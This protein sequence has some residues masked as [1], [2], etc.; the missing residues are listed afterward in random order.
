MGPTNKDCRSS[1]WQILYPNNICLLEDKIQN[2]GMY[3]FLISYGSYAMDQRSGDGWISG[4]SQI[5]ALYERNSWTRFWGTPRE[6]RFSTEPNHPEYP[7]QEKG[8]SGGTKSSKRGSLSPRKTDRLP[9]LRILPGHWRQW[10]CRE[11][12]RPIYSCSSK[13]WYSG[14]RFKVGRNS[15]VNDEIPPDDILEGLYKLRIQPSGKL[16]TVLE[17]YNLETHQKKLGPDYHRLKAMVKRSIEQN[18][19]MKNFE[20][21]NGNFETSAVVKNQ[22]VKQ[23]EQGSLGDCWQW[24]A[25][26]QCSKG[27]N[28]SFRHDIS[29]RAKTT[30]P[31]SSPR[32]FM[33]QNERKAS[34]NASRTRSLRGRSPSGNMARLPC[35]DCLKG[36]CTTPFCEKWH[37]PECL[38]YKSENGCKFGDKCSHA[39]RQVDEQPRKKAKKNS[40][41][42]V[43]VMLKVTRQLA[44]VLHD[45]EPP[46]SSSILRKSSNILKPT[47]CVRFTEAVLRHADIRDQNPSLGMICPGDPHQR[48]PNAPKFED[49]SQEETELQERCAREA[50]WRLAKNIPNFK[51]KH[52]TAFFSPSENWCLPAPSTLEP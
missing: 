33:Q 42:S 52:K 31:N 6:D 11:L 28:C 25:N 22:R 48:N 9:D 10:F 40:D 38:C 43:V 36:T 34:K 27:D 14:I 4:W 35:K 8:Q 24:K 45:M 21:R 16:K 49:R 13:W 23:R 44:C 41:K 30:Q 17:L 15:I 26:R 51:E 5:F 3:L 50:A 19:R 32:S 46:K 39:H 47:R 7:L 12:C 29:K 2:W 1:F 20:A 37:P 18:L